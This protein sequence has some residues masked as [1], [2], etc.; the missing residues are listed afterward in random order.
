MATVC[1]G[2]GFL[3]EK[4]VVEHAKTVLRMLA[5]RPEVVMNRPFA[6]FGEQA[7]AYRDYLAGPFGRLRPEG[8]PA[9]Q[10]GP[11]RQVAQHSP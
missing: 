3:G 10:S 9:L 8:L 4:L 6:A 7:F 1:A 2:G 11:G 5:H